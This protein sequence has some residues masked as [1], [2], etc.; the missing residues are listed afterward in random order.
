[1]TGHC[2][3]IDPMIFRIKQSTAIDL[4]RGH[5]ETAWEHAR[6]AL[7][8]NASHNKA[9]VV[10]AIALR[11][12]GQ[13]G[14]AQTVLEA[15]VEKDPLD[16]WARAE[17]NLLNHGAARLDASSRNDGQTALDIAFDYADCGCWTEGIAATAASR[18]AALSS[19]KPT[20]LATGRSCLVMTKDTP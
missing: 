17:L 3:K 1:M 15:I 7:E 20:N 4:Q 2:Q 9:F 5:F 8:T 13:R 12:L 6:A 19:S 14:E 11:K 16:H 10:E 18:R